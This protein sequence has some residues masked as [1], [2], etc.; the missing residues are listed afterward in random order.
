MTKFRIGDAKPR[1]LH[2][3]TCPECGRIMSL[4]EA[5]EQRLCD[6]CEVIDEASP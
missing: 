5:E 1:P 2:D 3:R 4:R 6:D